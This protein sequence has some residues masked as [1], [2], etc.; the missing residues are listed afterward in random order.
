MQ[1]LADAPTIPLREADPAR[2]KAL[3]EAEGLRL[4]ADEA[5]RMLELLGRDPTRV[6]ATI[7]DTMW[8][9]HCSYKSSR[10]VLQAHLPTKSPDV[11]LGPG[12]DAGV[13]RF[14][15]WKGVEYALVFAHE[16]HNHPSQVVPVEGAATGIGGIVR[17][18][19]CMGAEVIGVMD[20][21]RFGDPEGPR[22]SSVREIVRGVVDGIWQ[23]A[24]A[25]G[26]PNLG[27]DVF[28]SPRFDEN[29]LVN[30]VALGLVRADRIVRS[31][32]PEAASR[33]PYV[34]VLV[35][36]PTDETGFGGASFA[37]AILEENTEGQRG[38]VQVPDPFLKRVLFEANRAALDWLDAQGAAFGF[39]DLGAGGIAC[40]SSEL[41][42]AGGFGMDVDL[43]Q[44]PTAPGDYPAE[45]IACSETQERF[46]LVV[47]ERLAG[48][49]LRIYN[50]DYALPLV[51]HGARAAV[52]GRVRTDGRYRI[53]RGGQ[54]VAEAPVE[55]ITAGIEHDRPRRP[56]HAEPPETPLPPVRD[57]G[58]LFRSMIASPNVA[59]RAPILRYYDTEVQ[60]RVV[61][62]AGEADASVLAPVPGAPLG[63][64]LTVDGNPWYVAADPYWGTAHVVL[65]ALR[66]LACV[67][68]RPVAL[69]DCLNFG[70]PE[71]P[72][73]FDEFVRSVRG[74]GDA[75][76]ELA[77]GGPSGP[78]VAVVSGNVSFYNESATG[79]SIEPSPIVAA[80]GVLEDY[81]VAV[82]SA[83]RAHP[84]VLV[85][86]G[87]RGTATGASQL[88][89]L[90]TGETGGALP[91]L[92][93]D[94]ER[95]RLNA[96][97]EAVRRGLVRS[98]HDISEGGLAVAALE[99]ALGG[100]ASGGFG[101]QIPISA[102]GDTPAEIRLY[103]EAPGFLMEASNDALGALLDLFAKQGVDATMIGRT[104]PE[105]KLR[106][107]DGGTTLIEA[108]LAELRDLYGGALRP[109]VEA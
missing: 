73:V 101:L 71:D 82:S 66:N 72:E 99:M 88:R 12:E 94:L 5:A 8:S 69:T 53:L 41:A 39:K 92:D 44:I 107:M 47:P 24:N 25:L 90:L 56:R 108:D 100:F 20:A 64:A 60:A 57:H 95:R 84:G 32:V 65:E 62:R 61:I 106:F 21:L 18:V 17:D 89:H 34:F 35:G 38:H 98:C 29:C 93:F 27:G 26:V 58:A 13:V 55:V 79:R 11:I 37:S 42:A 6:E 45:V 9:E 23:Y 104:L 76:R 4:T 2:R 43:D 51:Y 81:S 96:V 36:K 14:G 63:C 77:P 30:V 109:Y 40:A 67:G 15:A 19:N 86:S 54:P 16:S 10:R 91:P 102:L 28:F 1:R 33:E 74:L 59:S 105:P 83:L 52:A 70:N 22:A 49:L 7:F 48:G 50:E 31:R 68:A 97:R 46:A 78:P 3:L 85:L 103:A 87:P 80:L 75:A